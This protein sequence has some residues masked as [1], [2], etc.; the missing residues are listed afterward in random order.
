MRPFEMM[1]LTASCFVVYVASLVALV[2]ATGR[3]Q[4][5]PSWLRAAFAPGRPE[6]SRMRRIIAM[7]I[8]VSFMA[9]TQGLLVAFAIGPGTGSYGRLAVGIEVIA[10]AGVSIYIARR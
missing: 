3:A 10:A 4:N 6:P 1:A 8:A 2:H 9:I 5:V 7:T